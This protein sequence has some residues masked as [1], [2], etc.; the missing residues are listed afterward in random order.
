MYALNEE[1]YDRW[2]NEYW[3]FMIIDRKGKLG[4]PSRDELRKN[5]GLRNHMQ[6]VA[7]IYSMYKI[8]FNENYSVD[9]D[10][11]DCWK[12]CNREYG[13]NFLMMNESYIIYYFKKYA[14]HLREKLQIELTKDDDADPFESAYLNSKNR[15]MCQSFDVLFNDNSKK[16]LAI[17]TLKDFNMLGNDGETKITIRKKGKLAG[18][19]D[20]LVE[21]KIV[22]DY[23]LE[24]TQKAF[25]EKLGLPPTRLNHKSDGRTE[26]YERVS[27]HLRSKI[28]K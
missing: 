15:G 1:D 19:I 28:N 16:L 20:A 8:F 23:P 14:Y 26:M 3:L 6:R 5:K 11:I 24:E 13:A 4:R 7:H 18:L 17:N 12:Y 22:P 10:I 25:C 9:I 21:Y 2:L 27:K